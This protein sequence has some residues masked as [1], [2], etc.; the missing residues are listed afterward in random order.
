MP[1]PGHPVVI[2]KEKEAYQYWLALYRNFPKTERFGLGQKIDLL[3][4]E[5][6]ELSFAAL[7]LPPEQKIIELGKTINRLDALKFFLQIAWENKLIP[8]N[9]YGELSQKIEE[10]GRMFGGWRKGL[11][12]K[13][14]AK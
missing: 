5:A 10:I 11:Q 3:F 8:T 13:L 6:L 14:S 12:N 9:K 4:I 1:P 7:Y 2:A